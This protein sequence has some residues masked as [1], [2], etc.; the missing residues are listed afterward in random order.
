LK[1]RPFTHLHLHTTNGSFLDACSS[2]ADYVKKAKDFNHPA[3][4]ITDHGRGGG[5][6]VHQKECLK[7]D[8]K[9]IL[10]IEMYINDDLIYMVGDKRKRKHDDHII[11]LASNEEGYRNLLKL[12]Y[13]SM[14]DDTHFYYQPRITTQELF[15]NSSGLLCGT[16]CIGSPFAAL[17]KLGKDKK[18]EE[19]FVSFLEIFKGNFYAEVQL[20]ELTREIG[21]LK[22]GQKSY[23]DWITIV[24][25]KY[26]VPVVVTGDVHYVDKGMDKIQT[27]SIAIRDGATIDNLTFELESKNL[28]YHN[29]ED[30]LNFNKE[31]GYEYKDETVVNWADTTNYIAGKVDFLIKERTKAFFPKMSNDDD[32]LLVKNAK[33]GLCKVLE[34]ENYNDCPEEYRKRLEYELS[35]IIRKG[36]SSYM[37]MLEDIMD[38]ANKEKI[39]RGVA[40]GSAAGSLI[41]YALDISRIDPIKFGLI[42]ER[43]LSTSRSPDYVIDYFAEDN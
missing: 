4:A 2:S 1:D 3:I 42:F 28:Y 7:A 16:A 33:I 35:I 36:F 30:L 32:M 21:D 37:L 12:N 5:I 10:G 39:S 38:Y 9:P 14:K 22:Q 31:Y 40:R 24:A 18:A 8:I 11:L 25:N 41:A 43:F 23:N 27:L 17:L 34:K 13:L 26:G 15:E 19:L 6:Y 29:V 20:N